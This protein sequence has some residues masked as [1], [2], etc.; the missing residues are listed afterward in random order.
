MG[1]KTDQKNI[2]YVCSLTVSMYLFYA[3]NKYYQTLLT[4][5]KKV[6]SGIPLEIWCC[7]LVNHPG[8][9]FKLR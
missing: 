9:R 5:Q 2:V 3:P 6:N 1:I 8:L 7:Q 4:C